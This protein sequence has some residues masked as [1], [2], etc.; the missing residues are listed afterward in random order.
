MVEA[1]EENAVHSTASRS[2]PALG[3][4]RRHAT[5]KLSV[6]H[7]HVS[8]LLPFRLSG[9]G[10]NR[11]KGHTRNRV[12]LGNM[13]GMRSGVTRWPAS[14]QVTPMHRLPDLNGDRVSL[15]VTLPAPQRP[16]HPKGAIAS[17][18]AVDIKGRVVAVQITRVPGCRL[19]PSRMVS[20][21]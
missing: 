21:K 20:R 19:S 2:H 7:R 4:P 6:H 3:L 14:T 18:P 15:A 9:Y 17:D 12:V 16:P 1:A 11:I 8:C 5:G 10:Q 13:Q